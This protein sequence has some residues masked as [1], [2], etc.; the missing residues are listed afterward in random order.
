[1]IAVRASSSGSAPSSVT[2]RSVSSTPVAVAA[3]GEGARLVWMTIFLFAPS[4]LAAPGAGSV[5]TAL[6]PAASRIVP[7]LRDSAVVV[8]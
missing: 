2:T 4:E 8:V 1:M 5:S 7:P 3:V 6:F